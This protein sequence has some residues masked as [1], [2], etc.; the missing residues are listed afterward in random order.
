MSIVQLF[1]SFRFIH[2]RGKRGELKWE[3]V[4][5]AEMDKVRELEAAR[6]VHR[7]DIC[8]DESVGL[9]SARL[10]RERQWYQSPSL[11][12]VSLNQE[13]R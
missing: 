11:D 4:A 2:L 5:G 7:P 13:C 3:Q 12:R 9:L 1:H 8:G 10:G 6:D